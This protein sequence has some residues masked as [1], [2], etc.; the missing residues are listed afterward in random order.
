MHAGTV[1]V[2]PSRPLSP[3]RPSCVRELTAVR[4]ALRT[5]AVFKNPENILS[6]GRGVLATNLCAC[7][8]RIG[9]K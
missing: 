9:I 7:K 6:A 2:I 4:I 3:Q 8:S 5:T 1:P